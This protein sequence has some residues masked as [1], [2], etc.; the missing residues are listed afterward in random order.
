MSIV[1]TLAQSLIYH[2]HIGDICCLFLPPEC[3][4][5]GHVLVSANR[6][7]QKDLSIFL[8]EEKNMNFQGLRTEMKRLS[9]ISG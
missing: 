1:F 6:V 9:G 4:V 8:Q 2:T 3:D 5:V 7:H